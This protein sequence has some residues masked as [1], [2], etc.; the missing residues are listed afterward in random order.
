MSVEAPTAVIADDENHLRSYLTDTLQRLWPELLVVGQAANGREALEMIQEHEPDIAFLDI[1]MPVMSGLEV[2]DKL[3]GHTR[4]VFVTAYDQYALEA[5]DSAALDYLLK[6]LDETRLQQTVARLQ[7]ADESV[8]APAIAP[9]LLAQ[10]NQLLNHDVQQY[11][12]WI[13]VG[14]G[15]TTRIIAVEDILYFRS[16][17]KYTAVR[18]IDNEF[19]I[20]K[21]IKELVKETD[22]DQFWQVHRSTLLNI[23][24]LD[25]ARRD[26]RGRY[27]LHLRGVEDTLRVSDS[28]SH[29]FKQM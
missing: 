25:R 12:K 11:L 17:H 18:T 16:D 26:F 1:R 14:V 29:L 15:G 4:V 9:G 3:S 2:A 8:A 19:V 22:P 24:H 13:R 23:R 10:L 20:R 28:F 27:T 7:K 21:T 6:P 5:F